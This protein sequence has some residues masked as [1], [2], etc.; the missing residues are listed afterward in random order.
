MAAADDDN[1][2][3]DVADMVMGGEFEQKQ[4]QQEME[5]EFGNQDAGLPEAG[6]EDA[7]L[8]EAPDLAQLERKQDL[9]DDVIDWKRLDQDDR[10]AA[11]TIA[12]DKQWAQDG[13][14]DPE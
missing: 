13:F 11:A 12:T 9:T 1:G 14:Y 8:P 6:F 2:G 5:G 3:W 7:E 4:E 10:K